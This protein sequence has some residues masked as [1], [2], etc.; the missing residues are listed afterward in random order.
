[1][2]FHAAAL[3]LAG[4]LAVAA[5]AYGADAPLTP[6]ADFFVSAGTPLVDHAAD[7]RL[8]VGRR[9]RSVAFMRFTLAASPQAGMHAVLWLYA[10]R[11]SPSGLTVR[12]ASDGAWMPRRAPRSGPRSVQ[13]GPLRV[14]RW[15]PVDVTP[16]TTAR[17]AVS[18][19]FSASGPATVV[20]PSR[21][22]GATAPRLA[23]TSAAAAPPVAPTAGTSST[24]HPL[25]EV[26]PTP[27]ANTTPPVGPHP[28]SAHPCGVSA[29]RP[30]WRHVVWIVMENHSYGQAMGTPSTPYTNALA[31][32]CGVATNYWAEA[33]P[34]LPNY[35]AMTSG[36]T[37]GITDDAAPAAH[38]LNV[39]SIFSQLG[40][41]WRS[42]QDAMPT[43]CA[44][45]SSGTYAVKH[46]PA[47][48]FTNIRDACNALD[49]PLA[50][51]VDVSAR[52]TFITPDLCNDTHDC[53]TQVGDAF[54]A[55]TVSQILDS[56]EY[57]SGTTAL[58]LTWDE[59]AGDQHIATIVVSPSTTPGSADGTRYDHY[60][61]LRTTEEMLGL[62]VLLGG[63]ALAPSMRSA[64]GL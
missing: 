22:A 62:P 63:A 6:S 16:L 46:N 29:T 50:D 21:E 23:F 48:Y 5:S 52:F 43:N 19:A 4:S 12:H 42:P 47:A 54:L 24:V 44:L 25:P 32:Q 28:S 61:L 56:A 38:P 17:S 9:P 35:I 1:M 27:P 58:F 8:V 59:G 26:V 33:R 39:P 53:G 60:S 36:S 20:L 7:T 37:Q 13:T 64:F 34:S 2:R 10:L 14:R 55:R 30:V 31:A 51:P 41:D 18:L 15:T 11:G 3:A 45:T 40:A 49:V 57:R